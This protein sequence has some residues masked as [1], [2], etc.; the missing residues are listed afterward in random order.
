MAPGNSSTTTSSRIPLVFI[1]CTAVLLLSL[2]GAHARKQVGPG[3][4]RKRPHTV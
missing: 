3:V 4:V 2:G 1:L